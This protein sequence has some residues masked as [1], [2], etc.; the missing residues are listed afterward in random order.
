MINFQ[1]NSEAIVVLINAT[2]AAQSK[3]AYTLSQASEVND[4]VNYFTSKKGEDYS[5]ETNKAEAVEA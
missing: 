4:A 2:I 3:G 5:Q 1:N